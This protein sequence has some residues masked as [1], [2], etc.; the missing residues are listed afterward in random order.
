MKAM[1][2][3]KMIH[4]LLVSLAAMSF[5]AC[6]DSGG[7]PSDTPGPCGDGACSDGTSCNA[8]SGRCECSSSPEDSCAPFG[9]ICNSR[10]ICV[11]E[12]PSEP[13]VEGAKCSQSEV[14]VID[15]LACADPFGRGD[16]RWAR[17]CTSGGHCDGLTTAC[18]AD[19][20]TT[21]ERS[22]CWE[23]RCGDDAVEEGAGGA[24]IFRNGESWGACDVNAG[25]M[26][27][28]GA[29]PSGT[30]LPRMRNGKTVFLCSASGTLAEE[31][32]CLGDAGL[33]NE[34]DSQCEQGL[35]CFPT[36]T[37]QSA[38]EYNVS[39]ICLPSQ[40]CDI[41]DCVPMPGTTCYGRCEN[42]EC[43]EDQ[44]CGEGAF[45]GDGTCQLLGRCR[46]ACNG[47]TAGADVG[48]YGSCDQGA[49][50]TCSGGLPANALELEHA[51]GYCEE[52]CDIFG[53]DGSCPDVNGEA[54]ACI[55][56]PTGVDPLGGSCVKAPPYPLTEG[57]ACTSTDDVCGSGLNCRIIVDDEGHDVYRC[58]R[59]CAC[60][61][62]GGWDAYG[63]CLTDAPRCDAGQACIMI[64]IGNPHLGV[65]LSAGTGDAE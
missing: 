42:K 26:G 56:A 58:L 38:C 43:E 14:E 8:E 49:S 60:E 1:S 18:I 10:K 27:A 20:S 35:N 64:Q 21:E 15:G 32:A 59:L 30:C 46:E 3:Q 31:E 13:A 44:E 48:A 25:V 28:P 52:G 7:G 63:R 65:C 16:R 33:R 24:P 17:I 53:G 12:K 40:V 37:P 62:E 50:S 45:C 39:G 41:G 19:G 47:G 6:S 9:K 57:E 5:A 34:R 23:N 2:L 29:D 22:V 4:I 11:E 54:Q 36:F 55:A 51:L 61:G